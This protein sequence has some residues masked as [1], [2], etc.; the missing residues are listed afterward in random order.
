MIAWSIF[1]MVV[2]G[3]TG[4]FFLG[5][6]VWLI[7]FIIYGVFITFLM[8]IGVIWSVFVF[9]FLDS[10]CYTKVDISDNMLANIASK[11]YGKDLAKV[12]AEFD[13]LR[14]LSDADKTLIVKSV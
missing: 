5:A 11:K 14:E 1:C 2:W 3:V 7:P 6:F 10:T 8:A 12:Q 4:S 13:R 9:L